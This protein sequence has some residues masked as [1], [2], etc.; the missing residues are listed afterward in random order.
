MHITNDKLLN[1]VNEISPEMRMCWPFY[2]IFIYTIQCRVA[3]LRYFFLLLMYE[4]HHC[5][6]LSI[7][8]PKIW[9]AAMFHKSLLNFTYELYNID[10]RNSIWQR[11]PY[12]MNILD[13]KIVALSFWASYHKSAREL[14]ENPVLK[15]ELETR[16]CVLKTLPYCLQS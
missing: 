3:F 12:Y 4:V 5:D 1:L 16:A 7:T 6:D 13:H 8:A 15:G 2:V 14:T 10:L 11:L 9:A